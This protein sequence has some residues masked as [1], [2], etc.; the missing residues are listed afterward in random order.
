MKAL[1]DRTDV[2]DR[3]L[4]RVANAE[5]KTSEVDNG[6]TTGEDAITTNTKKYI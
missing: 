4:L 3:K 2:H 5:L 1:G 6:R